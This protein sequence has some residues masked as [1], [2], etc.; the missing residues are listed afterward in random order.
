MCN[1]NTAK[2]A[3]KGAAKTVFQVQTA[4]M[5]KDFE[6]EPEARIF[7]AMHNGRVVIK[8]K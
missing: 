4:G 6:D 7:A 3:S 2:A 1:C 5:T 8:K